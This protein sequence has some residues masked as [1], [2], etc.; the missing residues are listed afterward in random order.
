MAKSI[1]NAGGLIHITADEASLKTVLPRIPEFARQAGLH[2]LSPLV[3]PE[4]GEYY[5]L[6]KTAGEEDG[7]RFE[8][9][10]LSSQVGYAA[11]SVYLDGLTMREKAALT[12]LCHWMRG[13][14]LWERIRTTGGAY[15]ASALF[16]ISTEIFSMSTYRDPSPLESIKTF[17][18][19]LDD[20]CAMRFSDTDVSRAVTGTY[21]DVTKP[22]SPQSRGA[23][24][25][26]RKLYAMTHE[27]WSEYIAA[28]LS[29]DAASLRTAAEN[30]RAIAEG[31]TA[32]IC[33][34]SVKGT[35]FIIDLSL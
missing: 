19:C 3:R 27:E 1:R 13:N 35:G 24:G 15:G 32:V 21:G 6:V 17:K 23:R 34:K 28:I 11:Q 33:D 30:A 31:N 9:C 5:A 8:T 26:L 25:F 10:T 2:A 22:Q 20:V 16:D 29:V 14:I 4:N 7:E 12:V 18:S